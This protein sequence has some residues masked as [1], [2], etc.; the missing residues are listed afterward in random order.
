[1]LNDSWD[2]QLIQRYKKTDSKF[3]HAY[4]NGRDYET[5]ALGATAE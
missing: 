1:M 4:C 3:N 5:V 2:A